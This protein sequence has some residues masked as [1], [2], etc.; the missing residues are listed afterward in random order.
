MR[1]SRIVSP[2]VIVISWLLAFAT[3]LALDQLSPTPPGFFG[4]SLFYVLST[5]SEHAALISLAGLNLYPLL[6][7]PSPESSKVAYTVFTIGKLSVKVIPLYFGLISFFGACGVSAWWFARIA[8]KHQALSPVQVTVTLLALAAFC[9]LFMNTLLS[10]THERYL[11]HYGFFVFPV[12]CVF[13]QQRIISPFMTLL[14]LAHLMIYGCFV[15]SLIIG[16]Q[17]F[18]WAVDARRYVA[19]MNI[20]LSVYALWLLRRISSRSP[21]STNEG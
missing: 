1:A 14:C 16:E 11:Y 13:T 17:N 7:L 12:L 2:L 3:C 19:V 20:A 5:G 9:N 21:P 18:R 6:G 10:G 4:S 8:R 15:Y